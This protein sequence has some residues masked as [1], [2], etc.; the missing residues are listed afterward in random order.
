MHQ[1]TTGIRVLSTSNA[2]TSVSGGVSP[3][4]LHR[5][6]L[7]LPHPA[8][9]PASGIFHTSVDG[10]AHAGPSIEMQ[11]SFIRKKP[12][13]ATPA[14]VAVTATATAADATATASAATSVAAAP[15][16]G[17][18]AP[19]QQ[20]QRHGKTESGNAQ[21]D[22]RQQQQ[23]EG[24]SKRKGEGSSAKE[25]QQQGPAKRARHGGVASEMGRPHLHRADPT[26]SVQYR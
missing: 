4:E 2:Y 8:A 17:E 25:T 6:T 7:H 13:G 16:T 21:G 3:S 10:G 23:G 9:S 20:P 19:Q 24:G 5:R 12:E 1:C 11:L 22:Q 18:G 14:T 15:S 26:G